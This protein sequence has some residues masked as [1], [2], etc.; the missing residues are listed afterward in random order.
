MV[1]D[2]QGW[3]AVAAAEITIDSA[4]DESVCP[5]DW[6]RTFKTTAVPEQ[7]KMMFR[8]ASGGK[9][10]HYGEKR[11]DFVTGARDEVMRMHFQVSDV[12]RPLAAV[13]RIAERGS[14]VQFGPKPEDNFIKHL[15]TGRKIGIRRKGRSY[16]MDVEAVKKAGPQDEDFTWQA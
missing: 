16:V 8:N 6:L 15:E 14:I 13:C 11:V 3:K 5:Q 9:M 4:A 12:Q 10:A 7:S 1:T 2:D